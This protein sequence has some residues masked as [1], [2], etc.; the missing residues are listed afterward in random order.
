M[1]Y[2]TEQQWSVFLEKPLLEYSASG[3]NIMKQ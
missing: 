1:A 3:G 2:R